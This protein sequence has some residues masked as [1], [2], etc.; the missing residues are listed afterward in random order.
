D[1]MLEEILDKLAARKSGKGWM[2]RCPAHEDSN[3][4]LSIDEKDGLILF[5]DHGGQCTTENICAAIGIT[6]R[7][8]HVDDKPRAEIVATRSDMMLEEIL[9]K[10]AAR[11]S[12]KGWMARCPAHE[13]SNPSLSI[14][15]KDG[16][17]LFYDHGGQC[18]TENICAAIGITTRDL[19]VDDKPRAEIVAT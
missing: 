13:D 8:L 10:L 18:T 6:T 4:S 14:D 3:P 1:M 5:Y 19:H 15:E 17:I 7:D 16:L 9:D 12:G 2:A 11:K